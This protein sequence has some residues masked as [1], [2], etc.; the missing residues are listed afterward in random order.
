VH[1]QPEQESIFRIVFGGWLRFGGIF[2]Y[3]YTVFEGDD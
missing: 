3:I 2:S 1:P